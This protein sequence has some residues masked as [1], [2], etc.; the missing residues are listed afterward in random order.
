MGTVP[1]E[2]PVQLANNCRPDSCLLEFMRFIVRVREIS[3][4]CMSVFCTN[5]CGV[6]ACHMSKG[7]QILCRAHPDI[8][9]SLRQAAGLT[10][11]RHMQ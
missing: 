4:F 9:M 3:I 6:Y 8:C 5:Y 7:V 1:D 11:S 2:L 10:H